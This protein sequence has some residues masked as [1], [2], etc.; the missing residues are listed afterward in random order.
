[1][2]LSAFGN[3][4]RVWQSQYPAANLTASDWDNIP[5]REEGYLNLSISGRRSALGTFTPLPLWPLPNT[6]AV[7]LEADWRILH[8]GP[9][10]PEEARYDALIAEF[11]RYDPA[12]VLALLM[13]APPDQWEAY[14]ARA[15]GWRRYQREAILTQPGLV[16]NPVE[17]LKLVS[18]LAT[19][20]PDIEVMAQVDRLLLQFPPDAEAPKR[21]R[22]KDRRDAD[23]SPM[24]DGGAG[25][26][27]LVTQRPVVLVPTQA[28][29]STAAGR[30]EQLSEGGGEDLDTIIF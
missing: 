25:D 3:D 19:A 5:I 14:K 13:Q 29:T 7:P 12:D 17:R 23:I 20:M 15:Q 24:A 22:K 30:D 8:P 10:T 4:G 28:G 6:R 18:W 26:G 27:V 1:M 21:E 11:A 9:T 16:P 2:I